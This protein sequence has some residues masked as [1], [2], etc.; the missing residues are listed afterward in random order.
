MRPVSQGL[1]LKAEVLEAQPFYPERSQIEVELVYAVLRAHTESPSVER[2]TL[3]C[4]LGQQW[5]TAPGTMWLSKHLPAG[6]SL[7]PGSHNSASWTRHPKAAG[8]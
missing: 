4:S 1:L 5:F 2:E 8:H 7:P 3:G 6:H